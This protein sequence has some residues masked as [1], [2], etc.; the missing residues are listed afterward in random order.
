MNVSTQCRLVTLDPDPESME[1]NIN[2]GPTLID[3]AIMKSSWLKDALG[4]LDK[5]CERVT[6]TFS[7]EDPCFRLQGDG[8]N[9]SFQVH[10]PATAKQSAAGF[11]FTQNR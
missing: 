7:P 10:D 4:D 5:T 9:G 1:L 8:A 11:I 2:E 6:M 3:R